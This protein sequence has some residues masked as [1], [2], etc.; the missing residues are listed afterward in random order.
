MAGAAGTPAPARCR[1][2]AHSSLAMQ[3]ASFVNGDLKLGATGTRAAARRVYAF[4]HPMYN[5]AVRDRI[6]DDARLRLHGRS[7]FFFGEALGEDEI[8]TFT[9]DRAT[10]IAAAVGETSRHDDAGIDRGGKRTFKFGVVRE[11]SAVHTA[12]NVHGPRERACRWCRRSGT[13]SIAGK[14]HLKKYDEVTF[15]NLFAGDN[16][17][18]NASAYVVAPS[19]SAHQQRLRELGIDS[20]DL[21]VKST[22]EPLTATVE[23]VWLDD[24]RPCGTYSG[25]KCC[26]YVSGRR[27]AA[28][29]PIAIPVDGERHARGDVLFRRPSSVKRA[30]HSR[31]ASQ[32]I[33]SLNKA[34]QNGA[35]YVKLLA[36]DAGASCAVNCSR[37]RRQ[38]RGARIQQERRIQPVEQ[39]HDWRMGSPHQSRDAWCTGR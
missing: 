9:Q 11:E 15:D 30:S 2:T 12:D 4:G 10:A 39:R 31:A 36:S 18:S 8:G 17:P 29:I 26:S 22:E 23:R 28:T 16:S 13:A 3:S 34:R 24:M 20:L 1:S 27:F 5:L 21:T 38:Y 6:S 35:L 19:F 37:R 14:V 33:R 7:E 32:L 25:S